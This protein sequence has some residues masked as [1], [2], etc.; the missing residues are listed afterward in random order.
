MN[1]NTILLLKCC[2][3]LTS[4]SVKPQKYILAQLNA[5]IP[6]YWL[7]LYLLSL[8]LKK[9][10]TPCFSLS[11]LKDFPHQ[12]KLKQNFTFFPVTSEWLSQFRGYIGK[13][14]SFCFLWSTLYYHIWLALILQALQTVS[15][16]FLAITLLTEGEIVTAFTVILIFS[17]FSIS[18]Y[19]KM[20]R[21]GLIC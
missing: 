9:T 6:S 11:V 8:I 12:T 21:K 7:W 18:I 15:C 4:L 16:N 10:H 1:F 3:L 19:L 2:Y 13:S 17:T 20:K 14:H 5:H